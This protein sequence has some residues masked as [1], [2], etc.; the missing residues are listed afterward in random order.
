M[1]R[2]FLANHASTSRINNLFKSI[3]SAFK[4]LGGVS[5]LSHIMPCS[6]VEL[7][8]SSKLCNK[9]GTLQSE[10]QGGWHLKGG[11][12]EFPKMDRI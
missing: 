7:I 11:L 1:C 10:T 6:L 5:H 2:P 12:T 8:I 4:I 3:H 9:K